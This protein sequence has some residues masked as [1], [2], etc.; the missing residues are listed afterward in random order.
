MNFVKYFPWAAIALSL[1]VAFPLSFTSP[2]T[3]FSVCGLEKP[4]ATFKTT[5]RLVTICRGEASFQMIMTFY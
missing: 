4:Q 1:N 2:V 3:A 5:G